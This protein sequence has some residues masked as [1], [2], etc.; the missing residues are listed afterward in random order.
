MPGSPPLVGVIDECEVQ[1][2]VIIATSL[3]KV[4]GG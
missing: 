2:G 1:E 4:V 3:T